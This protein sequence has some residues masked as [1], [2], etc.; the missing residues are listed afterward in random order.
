MF[1]ARVRV[2][3]HGFWLPAKE[4]ESVKERER[5]REMERERERGTGRHSFNQLG[6][7]QF[8]FSAKT[9]RSSLKKINRNKNKTIFV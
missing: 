8:A 1:L 3:V 2:Q 7:T 9:S 6:V 4:T 5:A